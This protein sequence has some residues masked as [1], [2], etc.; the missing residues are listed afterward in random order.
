MSDSKGVFAGTVAIAGA[1]GRIGTELTKGLVSSGAKVRPMTRDPAT[2]NLPEGVDPCA[3]DFAR[4]D[5]LGAALQGADR[6]FIS[7]GTSPDQAKNE[8]TLIDAA[9][10]SGLNH[11][12]KLSAFGPPSK[13]HPMDWHL[14]IEAHLARQDIGY[15]V[16]RP[17]AFMDVLLHA[18]PAVASGVWGGAAGDG[19]TNFIDTRDVSAV[20]QKILESDFDASAQRAY[21]LTGPKSWSMSDIATELGRLL[22]RDVTYEH[23]SPEQQ[24]AGLLAAGLN[25]FFADLLLGL[26]RAFRDS[27]QQETTSTVTEITGQ[28]P[29]NLSNWLR[30]NVSVFQL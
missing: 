7:H 14:D 27:T 4:P 1:T 8:I 20:A 25:A 23:R 26:D 5:T 3:V 12:V 30:E 28:P 6:L 17:S 9:V 11:I 19:K 2:A 21:H 24:R 15:T 29:R 10:A 18:G 22:E 16:L 13:L